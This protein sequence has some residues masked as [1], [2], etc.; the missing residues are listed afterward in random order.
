M[1]LEVPDDADLDVLHT[2]LDETAQLVEGAAVIST[3]VAADDHQYRL[4]GTTRGKPDE[5][6]EAVVHAQS[7]EEAR[8]KALDQ[9]DTRAIAEV[10]PLNVP[11]PEPDAVA[12]GS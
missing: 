8:A 5:A 10:Q 7:E 4:V 2:W 9:D 1:Q 6:W 12:A 11:P 3:S